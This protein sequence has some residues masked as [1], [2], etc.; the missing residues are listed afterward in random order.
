[1]KYKA[2]IVDDAPDIASIVEDIV[3]SLNHEHDSADCLEKARELLATGDYHYFLFDLEL[4][5]RKGRSI[6]RVQ[7]GVNLVAEVRQQTEAPIIVM[8]AHGKDSPHLAV[9]VM[10]KGAIDFITKPFPEAGDGTLDR[11]IQE[12]LARYYGNSEAPRKPGGQ[13]RPPQIFA[14][15]DLDIYPSMAK[16][17]GV[18]IIGP[19]GA[20]MALEALRELAKRKAEGLC[21]ASQE[22]IAQAIDC[23]ETS[24]G[25]YIYTLRKNMEKRLRK[26]LN[27]VCQDND[28]VDNDGKNGYRLK[29]WISVRFHK[30]DDTDEGVPAPRRGRVAVAV[31]L[32]KRQKWV[33]DEIRRG[34]RLTRSMLEKKFEISE[35]TAKRLLS[36]MSHLVRFVRQGREGYYELQAEDQ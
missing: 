10:K 23:A 21:G 11:K 8:T 25:G 36:E 34:V 16:L 3:D 12:A 7:N 27:I 18:R 29:D 24:I 31:E 5:F 17:L 14:G 26:Q 2:L 15:G 19:K 20:G 13:R 1:M 6:P 35:K 32:D 28:V 30:S 9:E 33:L 4:P 22:E